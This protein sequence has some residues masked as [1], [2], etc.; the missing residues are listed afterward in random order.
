[1]NCTSGHTNDIITENDVTNYDKI[2]AVGKLLWM[3][4]YNGKGLGNCLLYLLY[5]Y[6]FIQ[7]I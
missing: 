7:T 4:T 5:N 2:K 6:R 1:M 3:K